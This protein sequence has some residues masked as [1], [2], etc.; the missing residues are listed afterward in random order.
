MSISR[1]SYAALTPE[2]DQAIEEQ[3]DAI[4]TCDAID[5]LEAIEE[6]ITKVEEHLDSRIDKLREMRKKLTRRQREKLREVRAMLVGCNSA[7]ES[8][9]RAYIENLNVRG[10]QVTIHQGGGRS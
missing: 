10:G 7:T 9:R 2:L 8:G 5:E 4:G 3:M 1:T 6:H